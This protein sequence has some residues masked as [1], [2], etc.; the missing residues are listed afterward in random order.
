MWVLEKTNRN[1]ELQESVEER[2]LISIKITSKL[3]LYLK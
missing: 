1:K 2:L 3:P